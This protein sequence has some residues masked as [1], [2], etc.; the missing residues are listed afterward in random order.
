MQTYNRFYLCF[1]DTM[2]NQKITHYSLDNIEKEDADFNLIWGEKGNGKSYQVKHKRGV[3]KYLESGSRFILLRRWKDEITTEKVEHYF[4]DVDIYKITNAQYNC[5]TTYRKSIYLSNYDPE[6]SKT[7]RGE[8]IGYVMAL[9]QEQNYSGCSFLDVEDIIFEEFMSRNEYISNEANKL[10]YLYSTIDR[11]RHKV[12]VWLAGN[13]VSRVCPYIQ[14]WDLHKIISSQKQG[15]I[16]TKEI[17]AGEEFGQTIYAKLAIEYCK[18][19]GKSSFVFGKA[20]DMINKGEWQSDPQP[21]LQKSVNCYDSK[22]KIIFN[23]KTFTF[24]GDYLIDKETKED[25]WYIYPYSGR[26]KDNTVVISDQVKTSNYWQRNIYDTQFKNE[27]LNRL[28]YNTFRESKIFYST[29]LCGTDF[30][31]VIDFSIKR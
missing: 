19:T 31:Q 11:K 22:L 1:S 24:I 13:T 4:A 18:S 27:K 6:T 29:D 9:S 2:A 21:H 7:T 14:D 15:S 28:L 10:M 30:K 16:I 12:K 8:K 25:V 3:L 26:I 20:A 5:I 23:F 17:P